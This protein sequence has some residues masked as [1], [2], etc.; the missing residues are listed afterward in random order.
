MI[1]N[2]YKVP[3][4]Q[5]LEWTE[6]GRHVFNQMYMF[7][8]DQKF[9]KHPN[10]VEIPVN[11]W[12]TIQWNAAWAAADFACTGVTAEDFKQAKLVAD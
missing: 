6:K 1:T 5:W 10:A 11:H 12:K 9:V 2:R 7:F 8:S 3:E 4:S